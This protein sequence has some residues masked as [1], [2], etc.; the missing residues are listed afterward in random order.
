MCRSSWPDFVRKRIDERDDPRARSGSCSTAPRRLR[1]LRSC[2]TQ[3]A[4]GKAADRHCPPPQSRA[5]FLTGLAL[6][7]GVRIGFL[8]TVRPN[9]VRF[10]GGAEPALLTAGE[11]GCAVRWPLRRDPS[12]HDLFRIGPPE[13]T[14]LPTGAYFR[15]SADGKLWTTA[16]RATFATQGWA[17]LW[18]WQPDDAASLRHLDPG[19]DEGPFDI[20]PDGHWLA[21]SR[22]PSGSSSTKSRASSCIVDAANEVAHET[23]PDPVISR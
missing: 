22:W 15:Q 9:L 16:A 5:T 11:G 4:A 18:T 13:P 6:Y 1:L 3:T 23:R 17:G 2:E 8:P 20:S 21:S 19:M 14:P 10:T 7:E 12:T